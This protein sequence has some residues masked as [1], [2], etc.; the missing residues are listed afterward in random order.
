MHQFFFTN[1]HK[2]NKGLANKKAKPLQYTG[3]YY[4]PDETAGRLRATVF[5]TFSIASLPRVLA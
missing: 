1:L 3:F 2:Q 4:S 5:L